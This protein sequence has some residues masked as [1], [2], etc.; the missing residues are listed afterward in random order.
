MR[1]LPVW[2]RCSSNRCAAAALSHATAGDSEIIRA[3]RRSLLDRAV[4][5][6]GTTAG[7]PG[8]LTTSADT[9]CGVALTPTERA[10]FRQQ[11]GPHLVEAVAELSAEP[12]PGTLEEAAGRFV[13]S[14]LLEDAGE[15]LSEA[16]DIV[17]EAPGG[18]LLLAGMS[19][20]APTQVAIDARVR[21]EALD[22]PPAGLGRLAVEEAW[23]V[24]DEGPV[25]AI[26]LLCSR[27]A[28][29]GQQLFSFTLETVVSEGAVKDGFVTGTKEGE[30]FVEELTGSVPEEVELRRLDPV[31][32]ATQLVEAAVQGARCGLAPTE[33]GLIALRVFLRASEAEDADAIVQALELGDSLADRVAELEDEAKQVAIDALAR[34]AQ[35]WL[36]EQGHDTDRAEAG[37]FAAGLMGDFRAFQLDADIAGWTAG[38]LD[39][40]LLDWVPR[41]VSLADE[42]TD[43]FPQAVADVFAF[44]GETG[45][46]SE[47][48]ATALAARVQREAG[49]FAEAIA[50]PAA[51]GPASALV[52]AMKAEGV[53]IGDEE[54]MQAWLQDFNARPYEE[55]DRIL[56]PAI[57]RFA[58]ER[59]QPPRQKPK[60]KARKS[61]KQA[62]R[63]NRGR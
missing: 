14:S 47:R 50:N 19:I 51:G 59:P 34:E 40:F 36:E 27:E 29:D 46:L 55:R 18:P 13:P 39:E 16:L 63:R 52:A 45:R 28:V 62:R 37:A 4:G 31:D 32:A 43:T 58:G 38:E 30:R 24:L 54:A 42:E 57:D 20:A 11:V 48:Q 41:V 22:D 7:D 53:E 9:V 33:D 26:F 10:E 3:V 49:R 60:A 6:V 5:V 21:L 2:S 23:E 15:L 35:A 8:R 56:G 61:Q 1:R 12:N 25:R 44:L 17:A